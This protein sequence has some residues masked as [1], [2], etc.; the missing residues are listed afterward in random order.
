MCPT[1]HTHIYIY[2]YSVCTQNKPTPLGSYFTPEVQAGRAG[3]LAYCWFLRGSGFDRSLSLVSA[4]IPA[5]CSSGLPRKLLYDANGYGSRSRSRS[6][7]SC[8]RSW[9]VKPGG[10]GNIRIYRGFVD[11]CLV[12]LAI[13]AS[14]VYKKAP[15]FFLSYTCFICTSTEDY[16]ILRILHRAMD[17]RGL[18]LLVVL[19]LQSPVVALVLLHWS[20][21]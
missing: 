20:C 13:M 5:T 19:P 8:C 16:S 21:P 10:P 7:V 1:D 12:S 3:E 4:H 11:S 17:L 14:L 6:P 15:G 18:L 9:P 2:I